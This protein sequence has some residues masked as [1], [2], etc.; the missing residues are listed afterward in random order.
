MSAVPS[1]EVGPTDDVPLSIEPVLGWRV[2]HLVREAGGLRLKAVVHPA[3]WAPQEATKA[4]CARTSHTAPQEH[5]TCGYYA[6]SSVDALASAGVFNR[7]IGV[8][9]A[10][11]MWGTVIEH[12]RGARSEFAYPARLRLV[13]SQ[14][15]Q[16]GSVVDPVTVV[17]DT[18]LVPL[19]DR[20]WRSRGNG[21]LPASV[22][23]AELL[24][25]YGVELLP[26]PKLPGLRVAS[27]NVTP[28]NVIKW[29]FL[30]I[31]YVIRFLISALIV[32][33]MLGIALAVIGVV[34]SAVVGAV[35]GSSA[36]SPS[37]VVSS[38][39]SIS[40]TPSR[41]VEP[42]R[43]KPPPRVF[44]GIAAP[45]GIAHGDHVEL[46]R[47]LA[48]GVNLL[49]ISERSRPR[50]QARDCMGSVDAYT[51]AAH[52]WI[53]WIALPGAWIDPHPV[54]P[55]PYTAPKAVGGVI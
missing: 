32:L 12:A 51:R 7:G 27:R 39:P 4:R 44:P 55:N 46:A 48:P 8:I 14:C 33:W 28:A 19:C 40:T 11:A 18:W 24:S 20:H 43:R 2:W 41:I 10:V 15:L 36:A 34:V 42:H 49:G 45:C 9:G 37:V 23:Q 16:G 25:T 5:C 17:D 38:A 29:S 52:W 35:T 31:F 54:S 26:P 1:P 21:H 3:T 47:C 30:G 53:C 50:G 6:T 13:C 22:V